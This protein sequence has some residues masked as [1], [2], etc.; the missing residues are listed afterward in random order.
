[1]SSKSVRSESIWVWLFIV[2]WSDGLLKS[3]YI[4]TSPFSVSWLIPLIM[5]SHIMMFIWGHAS[6][7]AL[8]TLVT[9]LR[10]SCSTVRPGEANHCLDS[11]PSPRMY[12]LSRWE[13][14]SAYSTWMSTSVLYFNL[15]KFSSHLICSYV[16][17]VEAWMQLHHLPQHLHH[18]PHPFLLVR[19]QGPNAVRRLSQ[20]PQA[21]M[22]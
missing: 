1:M 20:A 13:T 18:Q 5:S 17:R 11:S 22:L 3:D 12:T 7:M 14:T 21:A 6:L 15:L 19:I 10:K 16:Q 9:W 2:Y 8:A 4:S